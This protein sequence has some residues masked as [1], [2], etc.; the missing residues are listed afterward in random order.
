MTHCSQCTESLNI[1]APARPSVDQSAAS[2]D[3]KIRELELELAQT[4]LALVQIECRS[5][6]MSHELTNK[7]SELQVSL[8]LSNSLTHTLSHSHSLSLS[9]SLSVTLSQPHSL[10]HTLSLSHPLSVILSLSHTLSQSHSLSVTLSESYSLS[11]TLSL[12]HTLSQSL[13]SLLHLTI[14]LLIYTSCW[15]IRF[16]LLGQPLPPPFIIHYFTG[17]NVLPPPP[18]LWSTRCLLFSQLILLLQLI[19]HFIL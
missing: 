7:H 19:S 18:P 3:K 14:S 11:V 6:E 1:T 17:Y 4:K 8:S 9:H 12:S 13:S 16:P 2:K 15:P 5:Q 10:S